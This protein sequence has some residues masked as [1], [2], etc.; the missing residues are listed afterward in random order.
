[1]QKTMV[2]KIPTYK[3]E[4]VGLSRW[5]IQSRLSEMA[6]GYLIKKKKKNLMI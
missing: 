5:F 3:T 2:S 6:T 4:V 1:M